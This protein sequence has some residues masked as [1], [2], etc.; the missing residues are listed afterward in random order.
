METLYGIITE[1]LRNWSGEVLGRPLSARLSRTALLA[2]SDFVR[3]DPEKAAFLLNESSGI[4]TLFGARVL[5]SVT[6]KNGW[7][8]FDPDSAVLDAYALSLPGVR[9][10]AAMED[11]GASYVDYRM[12]MLLR[13]PDAP[14]PDREPVKRAVLTASYACMRGKWTL[15]DERTVLTMTHGLVSFDRLRTEQACSR[16][17]KIILFERAS[18]RNADLYENGESRQK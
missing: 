4:C 5:K 6:E 2:S 15:Q 7:I 11:P 12:D 10:G 9:P 14:I 16:A 18:M 17:A 13:H 1:T 3:E 8:L